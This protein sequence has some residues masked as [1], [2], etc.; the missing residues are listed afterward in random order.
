MNAKLILKAVF[1]MI[2]LL[3]LVLMGMHN[4][5]PVAFR[6]PPLVTKIT[7]RSGL[8][9]FSFFAVGFLTATLL[10]AGGKDGAG[11]AKTPKAK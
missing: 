9:Y 5:E 6:L 4:S 8:M 7:Q 3:L 1:L 11:A 10:M 2:M